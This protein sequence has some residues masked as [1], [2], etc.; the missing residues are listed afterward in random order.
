MCSNLIDGVTIRQEI[1][2]LEAIDSVNSPNAMAVTNYMRAFYR[3]MTVIESLVHIVE[4]RAK[5]N[6]DLPLDDNLIE[7]LMNEHDMD[8]P[9]NL[10][11][12]PDHPHFKAHRNGVKAMIR[13]LNKH[14]YKKPP[15]PVN[16][17]I[18][19]GH[20]FDGHFATCRY[21]EPVSGVLLN[22]V[23]YVD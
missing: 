12:S 5:N 18:H 20:R 10:L 4:G 2:A 23:K 3:A 11:A 7:A 8:V 13:F 15:E 19:C 16:G 9:D 6:L 1:A 22:E 14:G 21:F 17:C